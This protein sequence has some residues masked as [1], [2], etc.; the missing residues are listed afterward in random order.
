MLLYNNIKVKLKPTILHSYSFKILLFLIDI[1][2]YMWC[3][4]MLMFSWWFQIWLN[5]QSLFHQRSLLV[6]ASST[7]LLSQCGQYSSAS[8]WVIIY[9]Q[10]ESCPFWMSSCRP[11]RQRSF[12]CPFWGDGCLVHCGNL[13]SHTTYD[14]KGHGW[15]LGRS[16][17]ACT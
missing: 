16:K 12:S 10:S 9:L 15:L 13:R 3:T 2:R 4:L 1:S 7:Y 5:R 11:Y 14:S 6:T 8:K 17:C